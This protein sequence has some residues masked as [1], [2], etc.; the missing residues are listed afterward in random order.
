MACYRDSF[1]FMFLSER[2]KS[3]KPW[4]RV[5]DRITIDLT[6]T[7]FEVVDWILPA[8]IMV[9]WRAVVNAVTNA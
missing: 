8:L 7:G 9:E 2:K 4:H 6:Q 1:T 3:W 5:Q